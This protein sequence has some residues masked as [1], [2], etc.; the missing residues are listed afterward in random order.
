MHGGVT[1]GSRT[2][3]FA[4]SVKVLKQLCLPV[5]LCLPIFGI[6]LCGSYRFSRVMLGSSVGDFP[7]RVNPAIWIVAPIRHNSATLDA[8]FSPLDGCRFFT[9]SP[10]G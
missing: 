2:T 10:V 3:R 1:S 7:L 6:A 4:R 8:F 5:G 9:G